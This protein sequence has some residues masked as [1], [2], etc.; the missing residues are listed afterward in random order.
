MTVELRRNQTGHSSLL[1]DIEKQTEH[2]SVMTA[3]NQVLFVDEKNY[4]IL[5]DNKIFD[6]FYVVG[7]KR[8]LLSVGRLTD[9]SHI[10]LFDSKQCYVLNKRNTRKVLLQGERDPRNSLYRLSKPNSLSMNP[11]TTLS[12]TQLMRSTDVWNI[13]DPQPDLQMCSV[14]QAE[15]WH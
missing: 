14:T 12:P 4:L 5:T 9:L 1:S 6:V 10:A 3:G 13:E 15:L 11:L 7:V 8:N 2:L